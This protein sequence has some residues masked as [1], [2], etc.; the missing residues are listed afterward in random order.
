MVCV[1]VTFV[2]LI[3]GHFSYSDQFMRIL[4]NCKM[5]QQENSV[6]L[7]SFKLNYLNSSKG[8]LIN[9]KSACCNFYKNV[10]IIPKNNLQENQTALDFY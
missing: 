3:L 2:H 5:G 9:F 7:H 6:A 1:A 10:R 8:P 4:N